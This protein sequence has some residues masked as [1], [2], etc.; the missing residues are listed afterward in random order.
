QDL[1]T[2]L[3]VLAAARVAFAVECL[4]RRDDPAPSIVL[5]LGQTRRMLDTC[6]PAAVR[7]SVRVVRIS[8]PRFCYLGLA[9]RVPV[10]REQAPGQVKRVPEHRAV[11]A[12]ALDEAARSVIHMPAQP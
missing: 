5:M 4:M 1:P 3:I 6:K 12:L 11:G 9:I 2:L 10:L 7:A 8:I